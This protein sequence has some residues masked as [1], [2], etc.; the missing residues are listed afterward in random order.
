MPP[1]HTCVF[2]SSVHSSTSVSQSPCRHCVPT[3]LP[4]YL[5][6]YRYVYLHHSTGMYACVRSPNNSHKYKKARSTT[7]LLT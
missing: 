4:T 5:P 6:T 2:Y 1:I 3:Y 7:Y